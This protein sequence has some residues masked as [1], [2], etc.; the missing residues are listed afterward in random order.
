[1]L[2]VRN[3]VAF[4]ALDSVRWRTVNVL[5]LNSQHPA[6]KQIYDA[7]RQLLEKPEDLECE[8]EDTC[9][10]DVCSW[11]PGMLQ[12][13]ADISAKVQTDTPS[14]VQTRK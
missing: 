2:L 11:Y 3:F 6:G 13:L 1:M 4:L 12:R 10:P 8:L 14:K 7:L 5:A 9:V